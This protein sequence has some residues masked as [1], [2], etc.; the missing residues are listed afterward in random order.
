MLLKFFVYKQ[1]G[2]G[3]Y[4][5]EKRGIHE[6]HGLPMRKTLFSLLRDSQ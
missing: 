1:L 4:L 2:V 6:I 5:L 3:A